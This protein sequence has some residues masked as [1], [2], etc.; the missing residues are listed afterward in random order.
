LS[1]ESLMFRTTAYTRWEEFRGRLE[2]LQATFEQIYRPA[3]Y[4]RLGLRYVDIVQRS[5]LGLNDVS[6]SDLLKPYIAGELSAEEFGEN[7][8]SASRQLHCQLGD[9]S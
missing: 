4:N 6:W 5:R 2:R 8:D 1:R 3:S 9:N 7:I